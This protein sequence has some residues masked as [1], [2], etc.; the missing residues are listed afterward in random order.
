MEN[1][2]ILKHI[3]LDKFFLFFL[4]IIIITGNF[5]YFIPYF[6]LL[7]IHELGHAITGIILGFKL[8]KIVFY[9][10]GGITIF[11]LPLNTLIIKELFIL[12]MGPIMQIFGYLILKNYYPFITT[13]HYT[14][15]I[16]NLLPIYPLDGGRILNLLLN[17]YYSYLNSYKVIYI[18]SII[19]LLTLLIYNFCN[20]NLNLLSMIMLL[21]F[22]I[23]KDYKNRLFF[24]NKFLLERYLNNYNFK[25]IKYI[26]KYNDFYKDREHFINYIPEKNYLRNYFNKDK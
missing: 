13:Y 25:K 16:F 20:F 23:I 5:N 12:I 17:Y 3:Y 18:I 9:P 19:G 14:L 8:E 15:L 2:S 21:L 22:K 6:L 10:L 11:N 26:S 7:F 1:I 24:Y 4:L